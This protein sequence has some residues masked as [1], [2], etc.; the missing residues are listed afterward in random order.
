MA[1]GII[2][3]LSTIPHGTAPVFD[4]NL[5]GPYN[6][7]LRALVQRLSMPIIGFSE[8]IFLHRP[9]GTWENTLISSDGVHPSGGFNGY[10]P[11][12]DPYADGGDALTHTTIGIGVTVQKMKEIKQ[13]AVD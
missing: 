7:A 11:I 12:S 5:T 1:V 4:A 3:V 9:N 6:E 10:S 2:P 8:E 13:K